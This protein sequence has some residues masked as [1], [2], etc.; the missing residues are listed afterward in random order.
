MFSFKDAREPRPGIGLT[1]GEDVV[2]SSRAPEIFTMRP[3]LSK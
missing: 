2:Q 3:T 1:I